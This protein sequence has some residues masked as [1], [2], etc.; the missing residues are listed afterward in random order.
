MKIQ[1]ANLGALRYGEFE[2]GRMTIICG[3]NNTGKTYATYALFGFLYAH[4]RFLIPLLLEKVNQQYMQNKNGNQIDLE[5]IISFI[6]EIMKKT[7][8]NYTQ[9]LVNIFSSDEKFFRDSSFVCDSNSFDF[10][11]HVLNKSFDSKNDISREIDYRGHDTGKFFAIQ[12]KSSSFLLTIT[13]L[14]DPA[15]RFGL[16][17]E[18]IA[19]IVYEIIFAD[20]FPRPFIASAERTGA[21]IFYKE[22]DFARNRLLKEISKAEEI[23]PLMLLVKSSQNYALPVEVNVNFTRRLE[24]ISK[25]TSDIARKFPHILAMFS[26]MIGGEYDVKKNIGVQF[27]PAK[28]SVRLSMSESSSAARS[29]LDIGFYLHHVAKPG[30]LLMIDE[31][32]L[33]LHPENQR[34]VARLFACLVNAGVDVFVTTHSDYFIKEIN[35]LIMLNQD[36]PHLKKIIQEEQYPYEALIL[37]DKVKVYMAEKAKVL[38]PGNKKRTKCQT[39]T[40]APISQ[41]SGIEVRSFDDTINDM[42]R[43]EDRIVWGSDDE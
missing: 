42:N 3:K 23:D 12:K 9:Q 18:Y 4:R 39:L 14:K 30:D 24:E 2:L 13:F 41:E 21:A 43:I 11:Q 7:S 37:E 17:K 28:Q 34:L 26:E 10:K 38:I 22:L 1:L 8:E 36:K 40:K 35:T 15:E 29:M 19:E 6:P 20:F 27:K 32:E 31:P 25:K 5:E 33:N 16:L